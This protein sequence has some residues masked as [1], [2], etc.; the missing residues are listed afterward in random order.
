MW[1]HYEL[2]VK[3]DC[4]GKVETTREVVIEGERGLFLCVVKPCNSM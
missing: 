3:K 4:Y 1:L 2:Q